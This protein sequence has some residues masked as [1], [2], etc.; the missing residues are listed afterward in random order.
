[1]RRADFFFVLSPFAP[2]FS[3][4]SPSLSNAASPRL[5]PPDASKFRRVQ[6]NFFPTLDFASVIEYNRKRNDKRS[7]IAAPPSVFNNRS[8]QETPYVAIV[9]TT[10]VKEDNALRRFNRR[11]INRRRY[12][13]RRRV[14]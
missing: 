6:K 5:T 1:L 14:L 10:V 12:R 13:R 2:P 11:F 4:L 8:Q 7:H 9:A 3:P